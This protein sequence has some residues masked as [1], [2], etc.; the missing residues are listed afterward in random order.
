V[1]DPCAGKHMGI[2]IFGI[3]KTGKTSLACPCIDALVNFCT[4]DRSG[5]IT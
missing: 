5:K 4:T 2:R 1:R 3:L